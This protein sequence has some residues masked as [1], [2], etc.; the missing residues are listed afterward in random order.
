[1]STEGRYDGEILRAW[2]GSGPGWI[3]RRATGAKAQGLAYE[4][5]L[6]RAI[7]QARHGPWFWYTRPSGGGWCQPDLLLVGPRGA[8]VLEAKLTWRPDAH[9][10][11]RL[12]Y[13]PVVEMA[14]GLPTWGVQVCKNLRR[15]MSGV[16]VARD[17]GEAL[18]LAQSGAKVALHWI[19]EGAILPPSKVEKRA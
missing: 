12:L 18:T 9:T 17:L 7:P 15:G 13:Q 11:L 10:K 8:L 19:G 4:R 14:L 16:E 3:Q 1:M 5:K 6:A 2:E